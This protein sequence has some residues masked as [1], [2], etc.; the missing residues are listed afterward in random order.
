MWRGKKTYAADSS[1]SILT[2]CCFR[3][4][5]ICFVVAEIL[6]HGWG[7]VSC[8]DSGLDWTGLGLVGDYS[9]LQSEQ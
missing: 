9:R 6:L 5:G 7:L 8:H 4:H 1:D 3:E 2:L